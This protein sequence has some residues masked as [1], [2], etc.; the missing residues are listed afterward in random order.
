MANTISGF[1][2]TVVAAATEATQVLKPTWNMHRS[3]YWDFNP[4][5]RGVLGQ[6]INVP[7]PTDPT[8]NVADIGSGDNQLSDVTANTTSIVFDRHP[9]YGFTIRDFEQFNSPILLRRLFLDAALTGIK[10]NINNVIC[11]LLT[12]SNFTTNSAISATGHVITIPQFL[13]GLGV[14]AD[15]RVPVE[16]NP[17]DMS[18]LLQ[19]Q[20]YY[21]IMDGTTG[22]S[23]AAWNQAFIAG[24]RI[25][26]QLRSTGSWPNAYG[27]SVKL[28]Q[29]LPTSGTGGSRTYTAALL[30]RWAVAGVSRPLPAPDQKVVDFTYMDF[31][32]VSIRIQLGYNL[33]PKGGYV[34]IVDA[35]YGVKVVRENMCQLYTIAE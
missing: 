25:A 18:L 24:N 4:A 11:G 10:N 17:E 23:G 22:G 15:Q 31:D 28:D 26:E 3:I 30:H 9:Q 29:Q 6:T 21:T 20:P 34:V 12:T 33:W 2:Q 5:E 1:F 19:S 14:L 7:I 35:G 16:N 13:Q 8:A 27:V 32:D